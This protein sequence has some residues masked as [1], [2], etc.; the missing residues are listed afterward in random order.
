MFHQNQILKK[1]AGCVLV[2]GLFAGVTSTAQASIF[3]RGDVV[4]LITAGAPPDSPDA[5]VDVNAASSAFSGVVSLNIRYDGQ[6]FICSGA[7]VGKRSV[8]SAG[9]CVDTDGNG[10]MVDIT[11]PGTDVRV[12]FNNGSA[13]NGNAVITASAVS[14]NPNYAGF[15]NCPAA[16]PAGS[17]CLND[18]VAVITLGTDAPA[19]AKIYRIGATPLTSG[20]H[21]VMA[22]YGTSGD[23]VNGFYISP[24]FRVKRTG[25]N[26]MDVFD[27]DDEL[28]FAGG[29][30][31]VWYADF[32]GNGIDQF[33]AWGLACTPVLANDKEA[34]IGGGDSGG[35]SFMITDSGEYVLIGNN[36]FGSGGAGAGK[37][38]SYFGGM[39]LSSYIDYLNKATNGSANFVPEPASIAM[40]GLGLAMLLVM[41][42]RSK[43]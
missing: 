9:H 10:T 14:M 16:T 2:A 7:L 37:F 33:C 38:G 41:R 1:M 5:R 4:P 8:V 28:G 26:Y 25:E 15:G 27:N 17:F 36:T 43:V 6:S 23:G 29:P 11:K 34:G 22:G 3:E 12:I 32:D 35:P 30:N 42:R 21:I 13:N 39:V 19:S 24:D 31:E 20:Q 18:D 40:L